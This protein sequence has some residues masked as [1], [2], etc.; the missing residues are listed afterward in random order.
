MEKELFQHLVMAIVV[1]IIVTYLIN[2]LICKNDHNKTEDE[3]P[4]QTSADEEYVG[5]Y[6]IDTFNDKFVLA[7]KALTAGNSDALRTG[8]DLF[9]E[10]LEYSGEYRHYIAS[11]I[12]KLAGALSY[13]DRAD[14]KGPWNRDLS[15]YGI[16]SWK[17]DLY[18]RNEALQMAWS[19]I[20]H[21]NE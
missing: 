3:D 21:V 10:S 14:T 20:S 17:F 12:N 11:A 15:G 1:S 9:V 7:N 5:T 4:E 13:H 19:D 16:M 2:N 6:D 18:S 8:I